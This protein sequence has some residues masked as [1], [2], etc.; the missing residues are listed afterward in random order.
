MMGSVLSLLWLAS[1]V[2][3]DS[4]H[5]KINKGPEILST[6]NSELEN[7][8]SCVENQ[9]SELKAIKKP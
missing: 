7:K 5:V 8:R 3:G 1:R 9:V 2:K 6:V 4:Q